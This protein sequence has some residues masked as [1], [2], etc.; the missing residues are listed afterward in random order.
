[1]NAQI[2]AMSAGMNMLHA[3]M[4]A[5]PEEPLSDEERQ[6]EDEWE[7]ADRLHDLRD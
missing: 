3:A 2:L 4:F 7:E 6:I 5:Q 1:M